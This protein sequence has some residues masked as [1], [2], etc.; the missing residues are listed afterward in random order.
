MFFRMKIIE[1]TGAKPKNKTKK[2]H[3]IAKFKAKHKNLGLGERN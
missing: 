2:L 1:T 3:L